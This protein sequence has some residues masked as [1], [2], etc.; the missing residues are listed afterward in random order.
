LLSA[1][2]ALLTS[3]VAGNNRVRIKNILLMLFI[4]FPPWGGRGEQRSTIVIG[5]TDPASKYIA[6][7]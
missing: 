2:E 7:G 5:R 3:I 4:A 6:N 1:Y